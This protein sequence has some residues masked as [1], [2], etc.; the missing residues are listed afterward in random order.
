MKK[1]MK[2]KIKDFHAS[3]IPFGKKKVNVFGKTVPVFVLVLLGIGLVSAALLT[4]YG[5]ITGNVVVEQSVKLDGQDYGTPVIDDLGTVVA[6]TPIAYKDHHLTNANPTTNALISLDT[7]C[8]G[9]DSCDELSLSPKEFKLVPIKDSTNSDEDDLLGIQE[10]A[11]TWKSFSEV[12]FEY[13]IE[14]GSASINSPHLNVWITDG[15]YACLYGKG[16]N[17]AS[18]NEWFTYTASKGELS[19]YICVDN[20]GTWGVTP[21][22]DDTWTLNHITIESGDPSNNNEDDDLQTVWVKNPKVNNVIVDYIAVPNNNAG[23]V[24][25]RVVDF[26]MVYD[27]SYL[28]MYPGTYTVTTKVVPHGTYTNFGVYF[29]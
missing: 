2:K 4:V 19:Q 27:F 25:S 9:G 3:L 1:L 18:V 22:V 26:R 10:T 23:N 7:T 28:N 5:T 20:K 15:T 21:T 6:G 16:K 13:F 14:D 17:T 11:D 12:S 29:P 8:A 24:P